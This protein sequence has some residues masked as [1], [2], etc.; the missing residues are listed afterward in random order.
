MGY[1]NDSRQNGPLALVP[2]RHGVEDEF[3]FSLIMRTRRPSQR[4]H[5][6]LGE[7]N[8]ACVFRP[9]RHSVARRH[10]HAESEVSSRLPTICER[11]A[12]GLDDSR[13]VAARPEPTSRNAVSNRLQSSNGPFCRESLPYPL[14]PPASRI[15]RFVGPG[16]T[17]E[18]RSEPNGTLP[19]AVPPPSRWGSRGIGPAP[20]WASPP[21]RGQEH[22]TTPHAGVAVG[23]VRRVQLVGAADPADRLAPATASQSLNAKSPATPKRSVIPSRAS[24][25]RPLAYCRIKF[26]GRG[27]TKSDSG[28]RGTPRS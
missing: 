25:Q 24:R 1:G 6:A 2:L 17:Q 4:D 19:T 15:S 14:S 7:G 18:G 22:R 21:V 20:R 5:S 13:H 11:D 12:L 10:A 3:A 28:H 27:T 26:S 23:R 9:F 8:R 16:P